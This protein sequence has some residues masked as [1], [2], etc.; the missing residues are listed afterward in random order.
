MYLSS[1]LWLSCFYSVCSV[2]AKQALFV[3]GS[4]IAIVVDLLSM[5]EIFE[6]GERKRKIAREEFK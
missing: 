5:C 1:L 6:V 4:A 2:G 3:G